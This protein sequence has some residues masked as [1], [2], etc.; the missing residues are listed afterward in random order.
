MMN[1]PQ[2]KIRD[3]LVPDIIRLCKE[4]SNPFPYGDCR[5]LLHRYGES[6][7]DFIPHLDLYLS[8]I[9]GYCGWGAGLLNWSRQK[10][11]EALPKIEKSFFEKHPE[12]GALEGAIT[13]TG[14]PELYATL[15]LHEE[16][17]RNLLNLLTA[18]LSRPG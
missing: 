14:T 15:R 5:S 8:D 6:Y 18:L 16:L 12:Y 2:D 3:S 1:Q 10:I 7:E 11:Q 17:R 13:K 4:S 9:A